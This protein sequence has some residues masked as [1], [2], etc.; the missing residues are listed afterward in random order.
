M[1]EGRLRCS[2]TKRLRTAVAALVLLTVPWG[3]G[4][5]G[6]GADGSGGSAGAGGGGGSAPVE[7]C[8]DIHADVRLL[9]DKEAWGATAELVRQ[10]F[11]VDERG[12]H[13]VWTVE[14]K[15]TGRALLVVSS[16]DRETGALLDNQL[17]E[18]FP[19]EVSAAMTGIYDAAGTPDGA[20]AAIVDYQDLSSP[21]GVEMK[22]VLGQLDQASLVGEW[23][24]PWSV[25][26]AIPIDV[27]WDG[28][29]F[30]VHA[31]RNGETTVLLVRLAPDGTV[32]TPEMVAGAITSF[33]SDRSVFVTD[34]E[35]GKSWMANHRSA[36][37]WL[38]G[39]ERDGTPFAGTEQDGGVMLA[40]Y[41][42][43]L[44]GLASA[45]ERALLAGSAPSDTRM[46]PLVGTALAG[47]L[48]V[49]PHDESFYGT[50][51][52]LATD[53]TGWWMGLLEVDTGIHSYRLG[54][55]GQVVSKGPL[56]TYTT[57]SESCVG[58]EHNLLNV[59]L[60][61]TARYQDELWFGFEDD[62]DDYT[63]SER[64]SPYRIVKVKEGCRYP[65]VYELNNPPP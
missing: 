42:G 8:V 51:K 4:E 1:R 13:L 56:V 65:T 49:L 55:N 54:A 60:F 58:P 27:G 2:W 53:G 10:P 21:D 61:A 35:S 11:W 38:S 64:R 19:T 22:V 6:A 52:A 40:F 31:K 20:F 26:E 3:C 17:F 30:A 44:L 16:F 62:T 45:G 37:T 18:A 63:S 32:L 29:A 34:A 48:V 59:Y 36:G 50:R 23:V 5:S 46:Q 47:E 43:G 25:F 28:E 7:G 57:C 24:S 9:G 12:V 15:A 41:E 39:H 14:E 33:E